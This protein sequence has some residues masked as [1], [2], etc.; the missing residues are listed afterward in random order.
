ME[1]YV[2]TKLS[3]FSNL[4]TNKRKPGVKKTAVINTESQYKELFLDETYD[5]LY[6]Y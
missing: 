2:N 5:V 3:L 1:D 6:A 4:I